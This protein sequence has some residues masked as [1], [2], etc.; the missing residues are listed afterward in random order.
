M[1]FLSSSVVLSVVASFVATMPGKKTRSRQRLAPYPTRA[2]AA[3]GQAAA[4][5]Q[6][7]PD[8]THVPD[9]APVPTGL[10]PANEAPPAWFTAEAMGKSPTIFRLFAWKL[11]LPELR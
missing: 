4:S 8:K 1:V 5:T 9:P 11:G 6:V 7:A 2:G 10:S 3:S